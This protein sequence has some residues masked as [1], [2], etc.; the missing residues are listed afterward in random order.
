MKIVNESYMIC[1]KCGAEAKELR[2]INEVFGYMVK[3]DELIPY[4]ECRKCRGEEQES[5]SGSLKGK[6]KSA[7]A[8]GRII[9]MNRSAFERYLLELGYLQQGH[10]SVNSNKLIPTEKGHL[11][12]R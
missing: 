1:T 5:R 10:K 11:H 7:F 9:H 12:I 3:N 8:W 6:W 4:N 2:S